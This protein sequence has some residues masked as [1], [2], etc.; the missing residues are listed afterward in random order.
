MKATGIVKRLDD[1][2][3]VVIPKEIRKQ[4]R[5]T[6]GT[7]LEFFIY[8][9]Y[10]VLGKYHT[11]ENLVYQLKNLESV[12]MEKYIGLGAEKIGK[13]ERYIDLIANELK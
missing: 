4:M 2:G 3:R 10:L 12:V 5:I 7:P 11:E 13:I 6:E 8:G 1:L 9:E